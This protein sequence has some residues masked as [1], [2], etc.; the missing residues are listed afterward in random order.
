MNGL[1]TLF[2]SNQ[3]EFFPFLSSDQRATG[4]RL[5]HR[6]LKLNGITVALLLE[7]MLILYALRNNVADPLVAVLASFVHLTMPFMLVGKLSVARIGAA[8]TW[9][10]GWF[11]RYA[12]ASLM[13]LAPFV[14]RV[15]PQAAVSA[16]I[17]VGAFGF[18]LFRSFGTVANTPL[19]GEV[20]TRD[21]RGSFLSGNFLRSYTTHLLTTTTV[22]LVLRSIDEIWVYQLFIGSAC[23][24]GFYAST[25]LARVPES[26]VP[27]ASARKP[28]RVA[29]KN[30]WTHSRVRRLLFA[31]SAGL[32]AFTIVIPF[33]MMAVK[34]GYGIPDSTAL[35]MSLILLVGG[36]AAAL[37][38]GVIADRVGPRPL[39]LLYTIGLLMP[40]L[41]WAFAPQEPQ[42]VVVG[43]AFFVAGY[44]KV[45][46]IVGLNQYF[47]ASVDESDRVGSALFIRVVSG[48]AAGL[49]G[50]VV[51]GGL[52]SVFERLGMSGLGIYRTYFGVIAGAIVLLVLMIRRLERLDEWPI[53][54]ILGLVMSPRDIQALFV[55]NRLRERSSGREETR[56][57]QRLGE[58]ASTVS[59]DVLRER[60]SSP[61]LSV[62]VHALQ[63]L[64]RID[65][66]PETERAI[67]NQL[68]HGEFTSAWVAAEILGEHEIRRAIPLLRRSLESADH[69]LQ[70]KSMVALVRMRDEQSYPLIVS[71]FTTSDNPRTII[72][73]ANALSRMDGTTHL[74]LILA[75]ALSPGLPES[76]VDEVL[77]AAARTAGAGARFYQFLQQYNRE[78]RTGVTELLPD[79]DQCFFE[80]DAPRVRRESLHEEKPLRLLT[81]ELV[82]AVA[83]ADHPAATALRNVLA[84][85]DEPLPRKAVFCMALIHTVATERERTS[86]YLVD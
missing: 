30:L 16:V 69:F 53:R 14:D 82:A 85:V 35:V 48:A 12:S 45:G 70:G 2:L 10:L 55:L 34:S 66:N 31:W 65:F 23:L 71:Y 22:I 74:E 46:I 44:C 26:S 63:A 73:G 67:L 75:K 20:T 7:N 11:F 59:E 37:I 56:H 1:R 50:S 81:R 9:G 78:M 80:T 54:S 84:A 51:G 5:L 24:I 40:T 68:E 79:L 43:L 58:I 47:L 62:R 39:L 60:L 41:Y 38:N 3:R 29:M 21:N 8:R 72:Y 76:V 33:M 32:V 6:F 52:L 18:A 42:L 64:G 86:G 27:R 13:V 36:I 61:R 19:V 57:V 15:A 83:R 77:T 28:L 25:V 4:R 17:L 49:A